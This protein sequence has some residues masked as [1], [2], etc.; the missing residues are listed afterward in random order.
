MCYS[1]KKNGLHLSC[2]SLAYART[3]VAACAL[4]TV[5]AACTCTCGLYMRKRNAKPKPAFEFFSRLLSALTVLPSL[6]VS[7]PHIYQ[8]SSFEPERS[9]KHEQQTTARGT[10]CNLGAT[11]YL[12]QGPVPSG[13]SMYMPSGLSR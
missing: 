1:T 9:M 3:R 4:C 5:H 12:G 6:I 2:A 8:C 10:I 11:C 13:L 7:T